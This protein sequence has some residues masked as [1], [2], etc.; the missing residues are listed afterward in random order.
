LNDI[1]IKAQLFKNLLVHPSIKKINSFGLWLAL[2]FASF[3]E[4]KRVI[5][6]CI[7]EGLLTDWFLFAPNCLRIS[8]PLTVNKLQI[9]AA[10]KIILE[11]F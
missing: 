9:E 5:D 4:C 6:Y 1:S 7:K 2:E 10:S 8:P 11:S 3:E